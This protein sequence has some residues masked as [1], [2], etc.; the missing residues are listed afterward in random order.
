MEITFRGSHYFD[1]LTSD[2]TRL[3]ALRP[4][5]KPSLDRLATALLQLEGVQPDTVPLVADAAAHTKQAVNT[6]AV[7]TDP[8]AGSWQDTLQ[9]T[10][11][12]PKATTLLRAR[13]VCG[14][15]AATRLNLETN[16]AVSTLA[17]AFHVPLTE[18][19][20]APT[21]QAQL[22]TFELAVHDSGSGQIVYQPS[23]PADIARDLSRLDTFLAEMADTQ[24]PVVQAALS[25]YGLLAIQPFDAANGR[26]ACLV[27]RHLLQRQ[28]VDGYLPDV[29]GMLAADR[30][31]FH[32]GIAETLR[33]GDVTYWCE[34]YVETVVA[35]LRIDARNQGLI[36]TEL[37][38]DRHLLARL[39]GQETVT[40]RELPNDEAL[41]TA[42]L[43]AGVI[44]PVVGMHGLRY[45]S[46]LTR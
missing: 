4:T 9:L 18:W 21:R 30:G 12:D 29:E 16:V 38:L 20:V 13:E 43:D 34:R 26:V 15:V 36:D 24:E 31:G 32:A 8:R 3:A 7:E 23:K 5:A 41:V 35:A 40:I 44:E 37:N 1:R 14:I 45:V 28:F 6:E 27:S 39:I 25:L 2:V 33:R 11:P 46:T 22:R 10:D 19:L 42:M 17:R